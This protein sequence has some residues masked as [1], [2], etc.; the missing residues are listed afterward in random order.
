M[1]TV[2]LPISA[3]MSRR[4]LAGLMRQCMMDAVRGRRGRGRLLRL[5]LLQYYRRFAE[6]VRDDM[7]KRSWTKYKQLEDGT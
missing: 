7:I 2:S 3:M 6:I 4:G 5:L 1:A